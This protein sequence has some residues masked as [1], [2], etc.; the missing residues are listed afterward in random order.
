MF[1]DELFLGIRLQDDGVL[2]KRAHVPRNFRAIQQM[3]GNV[4]PAGK[5]DV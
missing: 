1:E 5:G 3:H 2:V 4:L